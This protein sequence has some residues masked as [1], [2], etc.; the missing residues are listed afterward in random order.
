LGIDSALTTPRL[1]VVMAVRNGEATLAASVASLQRQSLQDLEI[2]VVDDHSTDGSVALLQRLAS[3]DVRIRPILLSANVGV[4]E[5]RAAGLHQ[6]RA[7]WIGFLDADD[8]ALPTMAA[9]LIA[10]GEQAD[11]DIVICGSLRVTPQG[12]SLGPK[13]RFPHLQIWQGNLLQAFCRLQFGTGA[14]WN[15]LYRAELI[16]HWGTQP[17]RWRQN[18]TEDTL[19]NIGC[20]AD[21]RR[22]LTLPQLL[23]HY[24]LAPDSLTTDLEPQ[25][26]FERIVRAYAIALDLYASLGPDAVADITNLYRAQLAYPAYALPLQQGLPAWS[27]E[28]AEPLRFLATE[29]P[30]ALALLLARLPS[31]QRRSL[32]QVL[33]Q[34]L[35]P[36]IRRLRAAAHG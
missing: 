3:Q 2:L 7:P 24:V 15:K 29:H 11:A 30:Q 20:F 9:S 34:Q 21:A 1:S 32:R 23:H 25:R 13:V 4:H 18:G 22:V 31:P 12:R 6:A 10:A 26:G 8:I 35:S 5:A 16:R 19:V 28:L 36:L 33:R 14:L 27:A 17:Q